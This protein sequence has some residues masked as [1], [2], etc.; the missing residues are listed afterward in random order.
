MSFTRPVPVNV[1]RSLPATLPTLGL[2]DDNTADLDPSYFTLF[3][4][5]FEFYPF[6][7]RLV[8]QVYE[9][10][11]F[12]IVSIPVNLTSLIKHAPLLEP[13]NL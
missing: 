5:L 10:S 8:S 12:S 4:A 11:E 6:N 1:M 2:I 7:V 9:V 13:E 3:K